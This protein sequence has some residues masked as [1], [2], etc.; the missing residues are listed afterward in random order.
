VGQLITLGNPG[1]PIGI[2]A[3]ATGEKLEKIKK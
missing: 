3:V 1:R 2:G